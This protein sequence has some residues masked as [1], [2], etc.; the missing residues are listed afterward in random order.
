[1][2]L[3]L[4]C[5]VPAEKCEKC[6]IPV[7]QGSLTGGG[8]F[9]A[10]CATLQRSEFLAQAMIQRYNF[11]KIF[12]NFGNGFYRPDVIESLLHPRPL[13]EL[14]FPDESSEFGL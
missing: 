10:C 1:M 9:F 5:L 6:D 8:I 14:P 13:P 11:V 2:S 7:R 12:S 3:W 4:L